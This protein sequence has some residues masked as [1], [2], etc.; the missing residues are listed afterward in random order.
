MIGFSK[1]WA[2][3][4]PGDLLE[5]FYGMVGNNP[6]E[7]HAVSVAGQTATVRPPQNMAVAD[8]SSDTTRRD[9]GGQAHN[10]QQ[11]QGPQGNWERRDGPLPIPGMGLGDDVV[12]NLKD[13]SSAVG[14]GIPGL[15][16]GLPGLGGVEGE[17]NLSGRK[18]LL[19]QPPPKKEQRQ[20]ERVWNVSNHG[21]IP[22]YEEAP[23]VMD[24]DYR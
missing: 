4:K 2:R 1:F 23:V 14:G 20:F 13:D 10:A 5:D 21:F 18:T 22:E 9:G 3:N 24:P 19:K 8:D 17:G 16:V 11:H 7:Q 12:T 15:G 6:Y